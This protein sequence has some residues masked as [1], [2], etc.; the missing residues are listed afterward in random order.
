MPFI[1]PET[2]PTNFNQTQRRI[3]ELIEYVND[4]E[5]EINALKA[6]VN[7]LIAVAGAQAKK[8]P[9]AQIAV[10]RQL[11]SRSLRSS[12]DDVLMRSLTFP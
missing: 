11:D 5:A 7:T 9:L 12:H 1:K 8:Q 3:N 2:D 10:L 4:L 6:Q